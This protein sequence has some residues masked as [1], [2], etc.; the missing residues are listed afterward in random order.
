MV[1][2]NETKKL[3]TLAVLDA[4]YVGF[5]ALSIDRS[6]NADISRNITLY[7]KSCSSLC[8]L[9]YFP[10]AVKLQ[11]VNR[12]ISFYIDHCSFM[13]SVYHNT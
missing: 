4:N 12:H 8:L 7:I 11:S 10:F 6:K 3:L 2:W 5:V 9:V 1:V 13:V